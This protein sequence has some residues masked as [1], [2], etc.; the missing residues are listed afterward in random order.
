MGESPELL[1]SERFRQALAAASTIP[2]AVESTRTALDGLTDHRAFELAVIQLLQAVEPTIRHTGGPGDEARDGAGGPWMAESDELLV[3]ISLERRWKAKISDELG[4]IDAFGHA[5]RCIVAVTNRRTSARG[6]RDLTRA[7]KGRLY[8]VEV[9]DQGWLVNALLRPEHLEL[10]TRLLG[11]PAPA[12]PLFR[13]PDDQLASMQAAVGGSAAPFTGRRIVGERALADVARGKSLFLEG[14][15]GVGKTRLALEISRQVGA[16][17]VGLLRASTNVDFG[18]LPAES[19]GNDSLVLIIDDAHRRPD[20]A[21]VVDVVSRRSGPATLILT[22]RPG[23]STQIL[24]GLDD[25]NIPVARH[26]VRRMSNRAI[27]RLVRRIEPALDYDR[28]YEAVIRI[29]DGNPFIAIV[30]HRVLSSGGTVR[31]LGGDEALLKHVHEL[32]ATIAAASGLDSRVLYETAAIVAAAGRL[33]TA[34]DATAEAIGPLLDMSRVELRRAV[35]DLADGGVL[36]GT[37]DPSAPFAFSADVLSEVV[38]RDAFLGARPRSAAPYRDVWPVVADLNAEAA[39]RALAGATSRTIEASEPALDAVATWCRGRIEHE[40]GVVLTVMHE[41]ASGVPTLAEEIVRE[42]VRRC[43]EGALVDVDT[44]RLAAELLAKRFPTFDAGWTLLLEVARLIFASDAS[45][46]QQKATRDDIRNVYPRVPLGTGP[47]DGAILASVQAAMTNISGRFWRRH[48]SSTGPAP[49][50]PE[51]A[52]AAAM[53]MLTLTFDASH[54]SAEDERTIF[55][56]ECVLPAS[57]ATRGVLRAGSEL[58][59]GV[60]PHVTPRAVVRT[61]KD[62]E[63]V[64]RA[65]RGH[66][67]RSAE[68]S[69]ELAE[70]ASETVGGIGASLHDD[71]AR[72]SVPVRHLMNDLLAPGA[73]AGLDVAE[74]GAVL[75]PRFERHLLTDEEQQA[76]LAEAAHTHLLR[77]DTASTLRRWET[78]I[79]EAQEAQVDLARPHLAELLDAAVSADWRAMAPH[80]D[81]LA[82]RHSTLLPDASRA[83]TRIMEADGDAERV[84]RWRARNVGARR[85]M[86]SA[87]AALGEERWAEAL[88]ELAADPDPGVRSAAARVVNRTSPAARWALD[89]ALAACSDGDLDRLYFLLLSLDFRPRRA[90]RT[91]LGSDVIEE[92]VRLVELSASSYPRADRHAGVVVE[93]LESLA[94]GSVMRWVWARIDAACASGDRYPTQERWDFPFGMLEN[95]TFEVTPADRLRALTLLTD[96]HTMGSVLAQDVLKVIDRGDHS[97]TAWMADKLATRQEDDWRIARNLLDNPMSWDAYRARVLVLVRTGVSDQTLAGIVYSRTPSS[98]TGSR[99][100]GIEET[101]NEFRSWDEPELLPVRQVAENILGEELARVDREEAAGEA[102]DEDF[103][104]PTAAGGEVTRSGVAR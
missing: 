58:L 95:L 22:A 55:L 33:S 11:L 24:R 44:L 26:D 17:R 78:W 4:R 96:D 85:T 82:D 86:T 88:T 8:R 64:L 18:R 75:A 73:E 41:A 49:G 23:Y 104:T 83:L 68:I 52:M 74:F 29:A 59:L 97:I 70:I 98:W 62:L 72:Y 53:A 50:A 99:R 46:S 6:L 21:Q 31:D 47:H 1:S 69:A 76:G 103:A 101:L 13:S 65:A 80:I 54:A 66:G 7:C 77:T 84:R 93:I 35:N 36:I 15:G 67:G 28:A 56:T 20:L 38:L 94:P 34:D 12:F 43:D 100:P 3:S 61:L 9:L 87:L 30:A 14:P 16:D 42:L 27:G 45:S 57:A 92:L 39:A 90:P 79:A 19:A 89:I 71:R 81:G 51:A 32:L 40:P 91:N 2:G 63:P 48:Q 60:L 102:D 25:S 5:P 37:G 10:R